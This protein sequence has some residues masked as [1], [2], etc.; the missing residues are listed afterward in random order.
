MDKNF[1]SF[2]RHF[3]KNITFLKKPSQEW[4][5]H[6]EEISSRLSFVEIFQRFLL[7]LIFHSH[8]SFHFLNSSL[9]V[10]VFFFSFQLFCSR[11]A[12]TTAHERASRR[13]RHRVKSKKYKNI[14]IWQNEG[15]S[16][17]LSFISR[18]FQKYYSRSSTF[19]HFH[20]RKHL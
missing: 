16:F 9:F 10:A 11:W 15:S 5:M 8:Y 14:A 3:D 18:P 12:F 7:K 20:F 2:E 4:W 1:F 19:A 13:R 17:F 6:P